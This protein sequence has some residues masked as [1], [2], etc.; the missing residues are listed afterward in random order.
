[1]T[2][3]LSDG[4]GEAVGRVLG[5]ADATPLQFWTA[6]APGSYLQL[7]DVVVTRA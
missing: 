6:V 5:T 4:S 1:M 2:D 7:D 3:D